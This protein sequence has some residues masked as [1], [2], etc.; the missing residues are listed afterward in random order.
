MVEAKPRFYLNLLTSKQLPNFRNTWLNHAVKP[1]P[2][3][4]FRAVLSVRCPT[5]KN[6]QPQAYFRSYFQ[7]YAKNLIFSV[8]GHIFLCRLL[9]LYTNDRNSFSIVLGVMFFDN[10]IKFCLSYAWIHSCLNFVFTSMNF[11]KRIITMQYWKYKVG[12]RSQTAILLRSR[13]PN[14]QFK[15]ERFKK[16]KG[17]KQQIDLATQIINLKANVSKK[18]RWKIAKT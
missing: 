14:Y 17:E 1:P 13:N 18:K 5:W 9:K 4:F 2:G 16:K 7:K 3:L 8:T 12:F 6:S 15:S 10:I 11:T